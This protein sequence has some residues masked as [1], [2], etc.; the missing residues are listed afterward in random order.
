MSLLFRLSLLVLALGA[1][2]ARADRDIVYAA[3]YY[4]PPG[5]HRTS[6]FHLY[7]INP[8]GT[9]RT[10]LTFGNADEDSPQW[11]PDGRWIAFVRSS[12]GGDVLFLVRASG[13][14][15]TPLLP[16]RAGSAEG[17]E[18]AWSPDSR[19]IA[20]FSSDALLLVDRRTRAVRRLPGVEQFVWS[21]DGRRAYISVNGA[22]GWGDGHAEILTLR[23]GRRVPIPG[24][25]ATAW[26]DGDSAIW[27]GNRYVIGVARVRQPG[28]VALGVCDLSGRLVR[29]VACHWPAGVPDPA[30]DAP[31]MGV[32]SLLPGPAGCPWALWAENNSISSWHDVLY[33]RLDIKAKR[34]TLLAE[35]QFLALSP[36]GARFCVAPHREIVPYARRRDGTAR[37]VWAAPLRVGQADGGRPRTITPRLVW[38]TG[39]D[40]RRGR[41]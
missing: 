5:D 6:H 40:W 4:A 27:T 13:G 32:A 36:D 10:Q 30:A 29:V 14:R 37:G 35:G 7:R 1:T 28:A 38:V 16:G 33:S 2:A 18:L 15:P 17:D 21:P 9:G 22:S 3:R 26:M 23:T 20:V 11:S 24:F 25:D 8:D 41:G 34:L 12:R 39:A 31:D 19:T